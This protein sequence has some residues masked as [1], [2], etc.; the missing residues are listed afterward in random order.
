MLPETSA[1]FISD[2]DVERV[3]IVGGTDRVSEGV[4]DAV[5]ALGASVTRVCGGSA[6]HRVERACDL[7]VA[8]RHSL[9]NPVCLAARNDQCVSHGLIL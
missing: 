2:N 6:A 4:A 7:I 8:I 5:K 9:P 3:V 1:G